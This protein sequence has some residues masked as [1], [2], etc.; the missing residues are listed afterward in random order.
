DRRLGNGL[1]R[2]LG[3]AGEERVAIADRAGAGAVG[4][5]VGGVGRHRIV[6]AAAGRNLEVLE[7]LLQDRR[8]GLTL[9]DLGILFVIGH[10]AWRVRGRGRGVVVVVQRD[11][12]AVVAQVLVAAAALVQQVRVS[13]IEPRYR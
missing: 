10:A 3:R 13:I 8:A 7:C 1:R 11:V 2:D 6:R 12:A 9:F 4:V 5:G